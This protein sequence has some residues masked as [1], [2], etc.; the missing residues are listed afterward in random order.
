MPAPILA[1]RTVRS[2]CRLRRRKV[3]GTCRCLLRA[4]LQGTPCGGWIASRHRAFFRTMF[5]AGITR[6]GM[7]CRR[8]GGTLQCQYSDGKERNERGKNLIGLHEMPRQIRDSKTA[9]FG[10]FLVTFSAAK[11]SLRPQAETS[12]RPQARKTPRRNARGRH[13]A[14]RNV[15]PPGRRHIAASVQLRI[16]SVPNGA[17]QPLVS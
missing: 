14:R 11:K 13:P 9:G 15:V 1:N 3:S 2:M 8:A 16:N 17:R 10:G 4:F 5:V 7:S 12:P 6:G